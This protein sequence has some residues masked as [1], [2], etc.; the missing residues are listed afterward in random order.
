MCGMIAAADEAIHTLG[1]YAALFGVLI[2]GLGYALGQWRRGRDDRESSALAIAADELELLKAAR[3]R[4]AGELR[5][6]AAAIAKLEAIV[7]QLQRENKNLRDLVMLDSI[8]PAL[9]AAMS[10]HVGSINDT[11]ERVH[12]E[13][14]AR[15][16]G[17]LRDSE[18]RITELLKQRTTTTV[19]T[20]GT[21][22]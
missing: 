21:P 17:E 8:P 16:I 3:D 22:E 11:T 6:N 1:E 14:R 4:M 9:Q 13:T 19:T 5:D 10:E 12:E 18:R 2:L 7:E 20:T 15:I